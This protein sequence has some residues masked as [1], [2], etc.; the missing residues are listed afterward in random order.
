MARTLII[1]DIHHKTDVVDEILGREKYDRVVFLGDYFDDFRDTPESARAT[2]E[3]LKSNVQDPRFT[4][5]YGN[6]DLPYRFVAPGLECSGFGIEKWEATLAVLTRDD[7][8]GLRLHAWVDGFLVTH[9]GWNQAFADERGHV[10]QELIDSLC[11]ECLNDLDESRMH[12]LVAA[13]RSRG[14]CAKVGGI[15]WQDWS[16]LVPVPGLKQIVGHTPGIEVRSKAV[17]GGT[18]VC[19][20]TRLCHVGLVEGGEFSVL[21]TPVWDKWFGPEGRLRGALL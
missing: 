7:W 20:D 5:L 8:S 15:V 9:A 14:G 12:P 13:G 4:F 10:T 21:T 3:W 6:H 16:E 19:L 1:P 2:A 11:A 17:D 18:A